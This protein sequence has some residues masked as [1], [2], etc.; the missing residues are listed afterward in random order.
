MFFVDNVSLAVNN[1]RPTQNGLA[2]HFW[3]AYPA[4]LT[5]QLRNTVI[6]CVAGPP[7]KDETFT[8]GFMMFNPL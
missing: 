2:T 6:D 1:P 8:D 3:A 7:N 4:L 5:D